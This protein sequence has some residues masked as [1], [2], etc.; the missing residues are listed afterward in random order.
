MGNLF[1]PIDTKVCRKCGHEKPL[2]AFQKKG[3]K[4]GVAIRECYCKECFGAIRWARMS[5]EAR[6]AKR[7]RDRDNIRNGSAK[8]RTGK[9]SAVRC[10]KIK[11]CRGQAKAALCTHWIEENIGAYSIAYWYE[12]VRCRK[13]RMAKEVER[14]HDMCP[15][16]IRVMQSKGRKMEKRESV[17]VDCNAAIHGTAALKR[18][19]KCAAKKERKAQRERDK[20]NGTRT[21]NIAQRAKKKGVVVEPISRMYVYKRDGF[22]CYVCGVRV[23]TSKTYRP[24]QATLDHLI[25]LSKGGPHTYANIKTCCHACNAAKRDKDADRLS[26]TYMQ[27]VLL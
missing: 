11:E 9:A 16:C 7:A 1:S 4:D 3:Q 22:K 24:D 6:E 18:C 2:L 17:C 20:V 21:H 27:L 25:P 15:N 5:D 12:C 8:Q 19:V 14:E 26:T 10:A 23:V 13:Q